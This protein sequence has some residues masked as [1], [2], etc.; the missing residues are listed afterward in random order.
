MTQ[1]RV[2]EAE[3][4]VAEAEESARETMD[5]EELPR[6]QSVPDEAKAERFPVRALLPRP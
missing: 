1:G 3:E 4:V 2:D 5:Q 6:P